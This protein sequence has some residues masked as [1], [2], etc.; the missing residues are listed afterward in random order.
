MTNNDET[1]KFFSDSMFPNSAFTCYVHLFN[2]F[3]L[4]NLRVVIILYSFRGI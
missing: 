4:F 2:L 1:M 3:D